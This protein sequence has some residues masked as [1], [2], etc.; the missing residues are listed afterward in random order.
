MK[1]W[2]TIDIYNVRELWEVK[3]DWDGQRWLTCPD[4]DGDYS[5]GLLLSDDT[6]LSI[7]KFMDA[8]FPVGKQVRDKAGCFCT[9]DMKPGDIRKA[10][11]KRLETP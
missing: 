3:P 9:A 1:V 7:V 2:I 8:I 5:V 10:E 11:L 6:S 4:A